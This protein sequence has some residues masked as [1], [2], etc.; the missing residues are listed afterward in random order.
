MDKDLFLIS[1]LKAIGECGLM[2]DE[3]YD[4]E[5]DERF[6]NEDDEGTLNATNNN[7]TTNANAADISSSEDE[8]PRHQTMNR[9]Q[10]HQVVSH[11]PLSLQFML[12]Q[13]LR[14][15]PPLT[16]QFLLRRTPT[17]STWNKLIAQKPQA[18]NDLFKR[19]SENCS[20]RKIKLICFEFL[21]FEI[22]T[23]FHLLY[24]VVSKQ[25]GKKLFQKCFC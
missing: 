10:L 11:R 6:E 18:K 23:Y 14:R 13:R 16:L 17:R 3:N 21:C 24:Y 5:N 8:L 9:Q 4:E 20:R 25:Y 22:T 12:G 1:D 15:A 2:S 7:A 19:S